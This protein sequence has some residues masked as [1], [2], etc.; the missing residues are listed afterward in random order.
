MAASGTNP[1]RGLIS[2]VQVHIMSGRSSPHG[3]HPG[4]PWREDD[5]HAPLLRTGDID[6]T[7]YNCTRM[8]HNLV[9]SLTYPLSR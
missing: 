2:C 6:R 5:E 1:H 3:S 8:S 7:T 4:T 9:L